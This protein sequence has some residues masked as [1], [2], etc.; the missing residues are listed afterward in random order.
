LNQRLDRGERG[1]HC[2]VPAA[3]GRQLRGRGLQV[4]RAGGVNASAADLDL[5]SWAASAAQPLSAV[6]P[7]PERRT[8]HGQNHAVAWGVLAPELRE[9]F[10]S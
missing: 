2:L 10:A 4:A 5:V 7:N 1:G 6:L 9:F 8:L 3:P